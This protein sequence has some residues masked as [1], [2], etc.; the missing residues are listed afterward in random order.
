ME[1][2]RLQIDLPN[3]PWYLEASFTLDTGCRQQFSSEAFSFSMQ[4]DMEL[5]FISLKPAIPLETSTAIPDEAS[6]DPLSKWSRN[7]LIYLPEAIPFTAINMTNPDDCG[8]A[9]LPVS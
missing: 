4:R 6:P 9:P 3:T 2:T 8:A 7:P 5:P 1:I